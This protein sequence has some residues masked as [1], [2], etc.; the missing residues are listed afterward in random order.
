[1]TESNS[2]NF[3]ISDSPNFSL[4]EE[5]NFELGIAGFKYSDLYQSTR[6]S[7][8]AEIFYKEVAR[9]NPQ[10]WEAWQPYLASGGQGHNLSAKAESDLIVKMA[11][12][13]GSFLEKLFPIKEDLGKIRAQTDREKLVMQ[14]KRN[15]ISRAMKKYTLAQLP[16]FDLTTLRTQAVVLQEVAFE[17]SLWEVDAEFGMAQMAVSLVNW[18]KE[19]DKHFTNPAKNSLSQATRDSVTSLHSVLEKHS[20]MQPLLLES[21]LTEKELET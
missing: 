14:L 12:Y 4:Q 18:E 3:S 9:T 13:L 17:D 6:L 10:L 2:I 19:Y 1:M 11:P 8:L 5:N 7:E 16:E 21:I 15:F 20:V